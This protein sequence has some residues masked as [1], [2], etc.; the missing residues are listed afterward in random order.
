MKVNERRQ[1]TVKMAIAITLIVMGQ[2]TA[3]PAATGVA[4]QQSPT[5]QATMEIDGSAS[6]ELRE[7]VKADQADRAGFLQGRMPSDTE[8][9]R[10]RAAD[11][12]R[13]TRVR[14][15]LKSNQVT[16][17]Q[18][19]DNAALLFQHGETTDDI[20]IAHE[21]SFTAL[22]KGNG[23]SINNLP[24]LA[25]DRFLERIGRKQRFGSQGRFLP[26]STGS[27]T[28]WTLDDTDEQGELAV[29]DTLRADLF[30]P[31]LAASRSKANAIQDFVTPIVTRLKVRL[32]PEW[33][34]KEAKRFTSLE[35]ARLANNPSAKWDRATA[36]ATTKRVL[37]WYRADALQTPEDYYRAGKLLLATTAFAP[38]ETAS[39]KE[40]VTRRLLLAHEL[41]TVAAL[42]KHPEAPRLFAETWDTFLI[43]TGNLQ[44]YGTRQERKAGK[45]VY[46]GGIADTT[47]D[48]VRQALGV[49]PRD[50]RS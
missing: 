32:D 26:R 19:F 45:T 14:Q 9:Q 11:A 37:E 35:L 15:I 2:T 10:M 44:R 34:K 48:M 6:A 7:M 18:D 22:L 28:V 5:A 49:P 21:L 8:R 42:R 25:E 24:I 31:P 1:H 40:T 50:K 29:T 12:S 4:A 20:L 23:R 38:G 27:G 16:T 3:T 39:E 13:L 43:T 30:M 46:V 17:A 36:E 41:A 47:S 33:Q